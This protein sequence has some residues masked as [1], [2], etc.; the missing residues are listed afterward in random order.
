M[1]ITFTNWTTGN[2]DGT[3]FTLDWGTSAD[4]IE[5]IYAYRYLHALGEAFNERVLWAAAIYYGSYIYIGTIDDY[6]EGSYL[7][8]WAIDLDSR[9]N[10]L[11]I[12]GGGARGLWVKYTDNSGDWD[13]VAA[14]QLPTVNGWTEIINWL[15]AQGVFPPGTTKITPTPGNWPAREWAWQRY[16]ILN[17]MRWYTTEEGAFLNTRENYVKYDD[18][19]QTSW[20]NAVST[21]NANAWQR[22]YGDIY[23]YRAGYWSERS[24]GSPDEYRIGKLY[25]DVD[26]SGIPTN[27]THQLIW[28]KYAQKAKY[29]IIGYPEA[30]TFED[31]DGAASENTLHAAHTST[32]AA[33]ATR[34]GI[35]IGDTAANNSMSEPSNPAA[36]EANARSYEYSDNG[37]TYLMLWKLGLKMVA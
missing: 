37:Y 16:A 15:I 19:Y 6:E 11:L 24:H 27:V 22:A 36:G 26:L 32:V 29:D 3:P 23:A 33:T 1:A 5:G 18:G 31:N 7:Y 13:G 21:F 17:A 34:T 14:N 2:E 28:Y 9:L 8:D 30:N 35:I 12:S 25:T 4:D 10:S 20:A